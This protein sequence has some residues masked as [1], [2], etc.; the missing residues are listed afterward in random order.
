MP[1]SVPLVEGHKLLNQVE[2]GLLPLRRFSLTPELIQLNWCGLK[3]LCTQ[4]LMSS[5]F[6]R[7]NIC[8]KQEIL[9]FVVSDGS[10]KQEISSIVLSDTTAVNNTS[11]PVVVVAPVMITG[12]LATITLEGSNLP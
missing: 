5:T 6:N 11:A 2:Q 4:A 7:N 8:Q 3:K 10:G 9:S 12:T 1:W